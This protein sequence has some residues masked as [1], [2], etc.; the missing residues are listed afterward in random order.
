M[1]DESRALICVDRGGEQALAVEDVGIFGKKAEDQPRHE[2]VQLLPALGSVPIGIFLQQ[3]DVEAVEAARRLDVEGILP[4][5]P[6]RR[7]A[8]QRQE[9]AEVIMKVGV[10]A[11]D[12]FAIDRGS[13][14]PRFYRPSPG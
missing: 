1:L 13:P 11:G 12:G 8:R 7:D 3:L 10:I 14:L 5:L 6:D 4:D 9:K 2:V